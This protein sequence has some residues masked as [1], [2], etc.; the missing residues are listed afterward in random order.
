MLNILN[1][2]DE[3]QGPLELRIFSLRT[4]SWEMQLVYYSI[5]QS[6]GKKGNASS[7][8]VLSFVVLQR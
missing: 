2:V 5:P 1:G 7:L 8:S 4:C 3:D 6:A